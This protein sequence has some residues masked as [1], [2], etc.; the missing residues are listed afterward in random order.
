MHIKAMCTDTHTI[1]TNS[2]S[3]IKNDSKLTLLTPLEEWGTVPKLL[4][5]SASS[6]LLYGLD[7]HRREVH[8]LP[9]CLLLLYGTGEVQNLQQR[10]NRPQVTSQTTINLHEHVCAGLHRFNPHTY[11]WHVKYMQCWFYLSPHNCHLFVKCR[12]V[13]TFICLQRW[14]G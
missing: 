14:G 7:S 11:W 13:K 6:S 10:Q 3:D 1:H 12:P 5:K 9:G 2:S 4:N 8:Q